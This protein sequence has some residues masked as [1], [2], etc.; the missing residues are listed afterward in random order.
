MSLVTVNHLSKS[1]GV[2]DLFKNLSFG[3]ER[4]DR[5]GIVGPNGIGKSSLLK[6]LARLDEPSSGVIHFSKNIAIGYLPQEADITFDKSLYLFCEEVFSDLIIKGEELLKFQ[7]SFNGQNADEAK[8]MK[9]GQMQHDFEELGGYHFQ[10]DISR[11]LFGLGFEKKDLETKL[12]QLS[13][14]QKTRAYL[15]KLLLSNPDILLLDEPTN[16]LDIEAVTWLEGYLGS[17][18]GSAVIISHDRYFLDK[19]VNAIIEMASGGVEQYTGNYSHYLVQRQQ[20]WERRKEIFDKEK[21]KLYKELDYIKKNISGQNTLQAKGKLKKLTRT[22]QAI[23]QVGL[24]ALLNTQWSHLDVETTTSPFSVDEAERR[25]NGLRSPKDQPPIIH[26]NLK[27]EKR[28]GEIVMRG[29]DLAIGWDNKPLFHL[30][31]LELL[32]KECAALIGPNGS[33]KSTF[34][35]TILNEKEPIS[36]EVILGASLD[37]GYFAQAHEGLNP[38]NNL[39]QE[40]Q[41]V[42]KDL[43]DNAAR[44]YLGRFLFSGDDAYKKVSVLSGGERGR[45][46]LAK[47]SLNK[48]NLLLLDEPSNHL[49]IPS[50][51]ILEQVLEAYQGTII[52]VSHDRY[53]I[54]ALATQ[55]WEIK[56]EQKEL[57][58]FK[59]TYTEYIKNEESKKD[60]DISEPANGIAKDNP[61]IKT[62]EKK[63]S[64]NLERKKA[65]DIAEVELKIKS[66]EERQSQIMN[67][68]NGERIGR[69]EIITLGNEYEKNTHIL[70]SLIDQWTKLLDE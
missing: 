49:D 68:L 10:N 54:D 16:H 21:E 47:L 45:L 3:I 41:T 29:K 33:G 13:G 39:I 37:V 12:N 55:I 63:N 15:A 46:A 52:L 9:L 42:S 11:V 30:E 53:L 40:V 31:K 4:R 44:Q 5:I 48:T 28:S 32:R 67:E 14:G 38:N 24:D 66:L 8:L 25:I 2:N 17:W 23:E 57:T 19:T 69:D 43:M 65:K 60:P 58:V 35:K 18:E 34:L 26:L 61:Q 50:Q 1:F 6:I 7:E 51:E 56:P 22:I 62:S 27:A 36:G 64:N 59:G 20:R 70:E